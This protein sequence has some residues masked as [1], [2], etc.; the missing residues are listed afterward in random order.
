MSINSILFEIRDMFDQRCEEVKRYFEFLSN[1]EHAKANTIAKYNAASGESIVYYSETISRELIK[2]LRANG[3]LLLY[4]LVESTLTNAI[5]G[6]HRSFLQDNECDFDRLRDEIKKIVLSNFKKAIGRDEYSRGEYQ[7]H[8]IARSVM[9][10]GYDKKSLF[11]GNLDGRTIKKEADRYGFS[12]A[13]HDLSATRDGAR[14]LVVK[15]KRNELAH[16]QISFEEC[17]QEISLDEL[18]AIS[19]ETTIYLDAVLR[20][21]EDYVESK[22]YYNTR[23]SALIP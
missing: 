18:M 1:V 10:W 20:G 5:D 12:I 22:A 9:E 2:T 13:E 15:T 8:P 21:V 23:E 6:I 4:N 7:T 16:G 3:Y 14:L 19:E 17:G 11:S